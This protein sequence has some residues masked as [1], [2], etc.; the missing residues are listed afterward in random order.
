MEQQQLNYTTTTA[1][2]GNCFSEINKTRKS[3]LSRDGFFLSNQKSKTETPIVKQLIFRNRSSFLAVIGRKHYK[4]R[5]LCQT[6]FIK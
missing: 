5:S 1:T 3:G 4:R 6:A 2:A